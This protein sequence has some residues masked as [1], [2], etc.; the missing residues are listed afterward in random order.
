MVE[1]YGGVKGVGKHDV[2]A[3]GGVEV[4]GEQEVDISGVVEGGLC[5]GA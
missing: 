2:G 3:N 4:G 5:V 1:R